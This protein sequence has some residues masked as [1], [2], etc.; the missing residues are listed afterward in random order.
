MDTGTYNFVLRQ[1]EDKTIP[2]TIAGYDLT[3]YTAKLQIRTQVGAKTALV[4]LT[5]GSGITLGNGTFSWTF[6]DALTSVL[7]LGVW[8]YDFRITSGGGLDYYPLAGNV[9]INPR[10]TI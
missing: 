6:T 3:T 7:P 9:T 2:F 8:V 5:N 10:I 1:G 4:T